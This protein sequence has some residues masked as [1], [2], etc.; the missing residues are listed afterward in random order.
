MIVTSTGLLYTAVLF[1]VAVRTAINLPRRI[2]QRGRRLRQ[3]SR[4]GLNSRGN[5]AATAISEMAAAS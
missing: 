5:R 3:R 4:A 2:I 1:P